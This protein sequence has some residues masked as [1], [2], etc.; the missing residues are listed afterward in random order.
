[1]ASSVDPDQSSPFRV[2]SSVDPDQSS[3]F[4]VASSVDPDQLDFILHFLSIFKILLGK[5]RNHIHRFYYA[6]VI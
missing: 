1:M 4:R 2:A 5:K 6:L 3:S